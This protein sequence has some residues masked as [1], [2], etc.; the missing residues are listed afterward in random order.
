M[1]RLAPFY[2]ELPNNKVQFSIVCNLK[3][4]TKIMNKQ[5]KTTFFPFSRKKD[6]QILIGYIHNPFLSNSTSFSYKFVKILEQAETNAQIR[7]PLHQIRHNIPEFN[8]DGRD[9]VFLFPPSINNASGQ[10]LRGNVCW[11]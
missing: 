8:S 10:S 3:T 7:D 1:I 2:D 9:E 6:H 11:S 5:T 4:A